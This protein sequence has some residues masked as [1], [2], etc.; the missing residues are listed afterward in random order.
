MIDSR[1]VQHESEF[2]AE[3]GCTVT[4]GPRGG[5]KTTME[6]WRVNGQVKSWKRRPDL[7]VPV[8][9]G[10]YD[11]SYVNWPVDRALWHTREACP[12][13]RYFQNQEKAD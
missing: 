5:V 4:V 6:I 8:K 12:V 11:Y 7:R 13:I 2:H 1:D 10:M 3:G 9:H